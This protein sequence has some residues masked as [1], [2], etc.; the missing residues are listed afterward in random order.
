MNMYSIELELGS[1]EGHGQTETFVVSSNLSAAAIRK[2]YKIGA[3]IIGV[4]LTATVATD[5]Q[6]YTIKESD[7]ELYKAAGF[8]WTHPEKP[9]CDSE[10]DLTFQ[11]YVELYLFTVSKGQPAFEWKFLSP[12]ESIN[13]GGYGLFSS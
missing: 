7:V 12:C 5:Y 4:N 13:I 2:S 11:R 6:D 1:S 8:S 9:L 10:F 3:K